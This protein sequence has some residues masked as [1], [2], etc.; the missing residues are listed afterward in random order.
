MTLIQTQIEQQNKTT[1]FMSAFFQ[2]CDS[3]AAK[4]QAGGATA[5][6]KVTHSPWDTTTYSPNNNASGPTILTIAS[7]SG[8][9]ACSRFS[10]LNS[11]LHV[12]FCF[13]GP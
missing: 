13:S 4:L 11:Q 8:G 12:F 3:E 7:P 6:P 2:V 9:G 10:D 5:A 1:K